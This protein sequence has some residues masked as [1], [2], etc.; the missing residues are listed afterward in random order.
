MKDQN[1]KKSG[2]PG[3]GSTAWRRDQKWTAHG[4]TQQKVL[5]SDYNLYRLYNSAQIIQ[6][7]NKHLDYEFRLYNLN[8]RL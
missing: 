7:V 8:T 6:Q 5:V 3:E 4:G 1:A 2:L